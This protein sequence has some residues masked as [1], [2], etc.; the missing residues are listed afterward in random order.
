MMTDLA[1]AVELSLIID[2]SIR[3][4][5]YNEN[6]MAT[7]ESIH[8]WQYVGSNHHYNIK[9]SDETWRSPGNK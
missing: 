8:L 4:K 1:H 7:L 6:K 2:G 5:P 3:I 9:F